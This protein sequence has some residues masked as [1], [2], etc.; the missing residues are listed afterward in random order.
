MS[1]K[2]LPIPPVPEELA[3]VAH[4]VF[5]RGNVFMQVRDTL[6]AIYTDEAK[7]R[8]VSYPWSTRFSPVAP[9]AGDGVPMYGTLDGS[10][11][12]RGRA[13]STGLEIRPQPG[14]DRSWV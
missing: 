12:C 1:L 14:V 13:R 3:R 10:P 8:P 4:A 2:F 11:G 6:G 7:A 5:P 9:G